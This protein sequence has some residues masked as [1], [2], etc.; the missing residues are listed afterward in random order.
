MPFALS[1]SV[2]ELVARA[3][4]LEIE[5]RRWDPGFI[6]APPEVTDIAGLASAIEAI[7]KQGELS[8]LRRTLGRPEF[9]RLL[10]DGAVPIVLLPE[11]PPA[12]LE[13]CVITA[14]KSKRGVTVA[15]V[16]ARG[17]APELTLT[18][19]E[20]WAR[21]AT[22]VV[23]ALIPVR[24]TPVL[25]DRG[26]GLAHDAS[27][28]HLTPW[29]R[30]GQLLHSERRDIELIYLYAV[31]V[32]LFGLTVPLAVQGITQ[33]VQGGLV[34]QPVVLLILFAILGTLATG[35]IGLLQESVVETIQQRIFA[36]MAF[37]FAYLVP[38]IRFE[39]AQSANL[40]LQMN[41]FFEAV[42]IQKSL[43][44]LL[45][46]VPTATLQV[47]FGIALLSF[48][49][50][51]FIAFALL[52][53]L[54]VYVIFRV[55]YS[56][57]IETSIMESKFK[58]NVLEWLQAMAR[59]I[60]A[61]K[62]S[63]RSTLPLEMMD[64]HVAN[65]LKYRRKHFRVLITQSMSMIVF[66]TLLTGALLILG[67]TL[68]VDRSLT[69][70]QFVAAELVIV[71]VL[72]GVE[73][74]I[75]SL[76]T[77]Y[78]VLTSVDKV[79]HVMDL[80]VEEILGL[81]LP[82]S[83]DGMAILA[84]DLS[85]TYPDQPSPTLSGIRLDIRPGE[86]IAITGAD[87]SG[88]TTLLRLFGAL[89]DGFDGTLTYDG[90]TLRSMNRAALREQIG[91]V[92]STTDL[93]DGTIEDNISVGRRFV[94]RAAVLKA[95]RDV[96][97]DEVVQSM[98][99]GILTTIINGGANLSSAVASKLLVAQG[100]VGRPRLLLLDDFFQNLD[101]EYRTSL[102]RLLMDRAFQCTV[103]AVSHDPEFLAACDLIIVME[104]GRIREQGTYAEL[105]ARLGRASVHGL[106]VPVA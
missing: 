76:A 70:G 72:A 38:R 59:S 69:L 87:G 104:G 83:T 63:T 50:P 4:E 95:L 12:E 2:N 64:G 90:V 97:V 42:L 31:L 41:R 65:Y 3:L 27:H 8:Y 67:T 78:D 19:D 98:P 91:Q 6:G 96:G 15:T 56:R 74:L 58:Y 71:T 23:H 46:D 29:Q 17:I 24:L 54:G 77:I 47:L 36:R 102:I 43:A 20:L 18:L 88:Q 13:A 57:G 79:G 25:S 106:S 49:N 45:L 80:P 81:Q 39:A 51:R 22:R 16:S 21:L 66:K 53:L 60:A 9:E 105:A 5:S 103:I 94:D 61:F 99:N 11:R 32:G 75:R 73:K 93:F 37:E 100:I 84:R 89:H 1:R 40:P 92:L 82:D 55:T 33:L 26:D 35:V 62:F 7:G 48:Y 86:R 30:L 44:K 28:E 10:A 52:L 34:L 101:D 68:V 85:F 14:S